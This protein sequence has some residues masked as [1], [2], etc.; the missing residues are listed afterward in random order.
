[1]VQ[2]IFGSK[3]R[4]NLLQN[5]CFYIASVLQK[6]CYFHCLT[7]HK[8]LNMNIIIETCWLYKNF[9]IE[10]NGKGIRFRFSESLSDFSCV[11]MKI[12]EDF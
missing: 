10:N 2:T 1:M 11:E 12:R 5:H 7:F 6:H 8:I 9:R 3:I 4:Q